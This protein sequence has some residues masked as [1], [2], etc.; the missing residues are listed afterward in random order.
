MSGFGVELTN[1]ELREMMAV[2][3]TDGDGRISYADFVRVTASL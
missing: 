2:A 1:D 3:D